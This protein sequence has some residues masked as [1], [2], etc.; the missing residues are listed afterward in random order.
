MRLWVCETVAPKALTGRGILDRRRIRPFSP[1][2]SYFSFHKFF[3]GMLKHTTFQTHI[4]F[5]RFSIWFKRPMW[6]MHTLSHMVRRSLPY[7]N[8]YNG[9]GHTE[10]K[11]PYTSKFLVSTQ[12][13][14]MTFIAL[15]IDR[16]W[17]GIDLISAYLNQRYYIIHFRQCLV[18][19]SFFDFFG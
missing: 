6:T 15:S 4:H 19:Y 3:V 8:L 13:T 16:N 7:A 18:L 14:K 1:S 5:S 11:I 10:S 12:I 2:H 17:N 9:K